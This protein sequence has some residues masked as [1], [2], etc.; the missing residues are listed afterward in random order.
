MSVTARLLR[1]GERELLFGRNDTL[2]SPLSHPTMRSC[3][4]TED[5]VKVG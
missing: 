5:N 4:A 1:G 3:R 2:T